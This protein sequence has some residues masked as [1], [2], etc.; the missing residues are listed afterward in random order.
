MQDYNTLISDPT[1]AS[2]IEDIQSAAFVLCLDTEQPT[3]LVSHS[4]ALWHG[5]VSQPTSTK[6]ILGLRNRW[7]DKPVQFVVF[8][9]GKAGIMGEHSVMDG[10]PTVTL[11]DTVLNMIAS[12]EWDQGQAQNSSAS[13]PVPRDWKVSPQIETAIENAN[14]AALALIGSQDMNIVRT[15]YGKQAIKAFSIS[16]DSWAQLLVQLA[17]AR[18]LRALNPSQPFHVS[19]QGATYEAATTRKFF[20]GRTEAIRVVSSESDEWVRSMDDPNV[21]DGERKTLFEKAAKKH[22]GWA[23][24]AGNGLGVDRHMLGTSHDIITVCCSRHSHFTS[25]IEEDSERR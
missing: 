7:V 4:R 2:I 22:I 11:C 14:Q 15:P 1:N 24:M 12:L 5:A 16:P 23:K 3:D 13:L 9:N 6:P 25:R 8:E 10:T 21:S 19:R 17:Y 18:L 20:K